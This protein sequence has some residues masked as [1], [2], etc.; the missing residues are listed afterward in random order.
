MVDRGD[1]RGGI[2]GAGLGDG[3]V[4]VTTIAV[5]QDDIDRGA[6]AVNDGDSCPV[7]LAV[8]RAPGLGCAH[9]TKAEVVPNGNYFE[10]GI[11]LP[12]VAVEFIRRFDEGEP[13]EP[14][15]F[16]LPVPA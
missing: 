12:D 9:V 3:V 13:V 16:T 4:G 10:P 5:T 15:T 11:P 6:K 7:A 2:P 1:S 14:F 8:Q